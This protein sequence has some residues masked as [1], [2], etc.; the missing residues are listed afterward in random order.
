MA[1]YAR[2][3]RVG[4]ATARVA[5]RRKPYIACEELAPLQWTNALNS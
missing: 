4:E 2:H 1:R 5:S 3:Y